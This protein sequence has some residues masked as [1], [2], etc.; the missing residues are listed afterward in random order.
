MRI[1]E[2]IL[3]VICYS[4]LLIALFLE[5]ICYTK[6]I[7]SKITIAFTASLLLFVVSMSIS[8]LM[9]SRYGL[10]TAQTVSMVCLIFVSV[11]TFQNILHE[12]KHKIP[13]FAVVAHLVL[14]GVLLVLSLFGY[15]FNFSNS[16]DSLVVIYMLLSVV[17]SM[18]I[19]FLT[20]PKKQFAHLEKVEKQF[21]LTFIVVIPSVV[22]FSFWFKEQYDQLQIGFM[23]PIIFTLL[24]SNK[25]YDDLKRLSIVQV[26]LEPQ[27]Q[28]YQ[29]YN[30]TKREEEIATLLFEGHTYKSISEQ[31]FI[32][33]PTVKTHASNVYKKCNV[34]N[35]HELILLLMS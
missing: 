9:E 17:L 27:K 11:T 20:D 7:E 31:L 22:V 15:L 14:G 19:V 18:L 32:S 5:I 8:P 23:V 30:F 6:R 26:K 4:S 3:L 33:L 21:A 24:A 13:K 29:N 35:K 28:K 1:I 25:I 2:L 16:V 10:T 12:R 34:K